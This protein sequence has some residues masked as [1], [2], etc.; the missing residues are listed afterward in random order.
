MCVYSM[1]TDHYW[2]KWNKPPYIPITPAVPVPPV[3]VPQIIVPQ[4]SQEEI[5]EFR[6]LLERAREYDKKH[7][8]P[9]CELEEKKKR[10]REL[11][12]SLGVKIDFL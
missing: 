5:D 6:K 3:M 8:E 12:E 2:E 9:D 10:V 7:G 4:I 1:V 11:A